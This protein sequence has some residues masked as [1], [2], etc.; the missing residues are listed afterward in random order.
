M[1]KAFANRLIKQLMV[2]TWMAPN[3]MARM[4]HKPLKASTVDN[5]G[6]EYGIIKPSK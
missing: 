5:S 2:N 1:T 6:L 4:N 3:W